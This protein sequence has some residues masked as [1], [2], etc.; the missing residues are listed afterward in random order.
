MSSLYDFD[1]KWT[2]LVEKA[3][4]E[5]YG[6]LTDHER[7]WFNIQ[8]L[9]QAVNNGGF[10]SYYS[11]SVANT[12]DDCVHALG[13]IG[14]ANSKV[15]VERVNSLFEHGVPKDTKKRNMEMEHWPTSKEA[16]LNDVEIAYFTQKEN[17]EALLAN[18]I[19]ENKIV[20]NQ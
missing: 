7:I 3:Y 17:I 1:N 18:F 8:C 11:S 5:D 15:L 14:A 4:S 20:L 19:V 16:V 13:V 12:V 2:G 10:V 9:I 6:T